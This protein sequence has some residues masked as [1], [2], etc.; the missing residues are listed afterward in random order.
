MRNQ[1]ASGSCLQQRKSQ[2][3]CGLPSQ[4][5]ESLETVFL[6][7]NGSSPLKLSVC[8]SVFFNKLP[9]LPGYNLLLPHYCSPTQLPIHEAHTKE[10]LEGVAPEAPLP[11]LSSSPVPS[12]SLH[13]NPLPMDY[14]GDLSGGKA[15]KQWLTQQREVLW[16]SEDQALHPTP[17]LPG[18]RTSRCLSSSEACREDPKAQQHNPESPS[19]SPLYPSSPPGVPTRSETPLRTMKESKYPK[20]S[21]PAMPAPSTTPASLPG[22]QRI[23]C[24]EGLSGSKA[25]W[26]TT[27]KK[28]VAQISKPPV[29]DPCQVTEPM[30]EPPGSGPPNV[31]HGYEAQWRTIG[32]KASPQASQPSVL[33]HQPP[34]SLSEPPN[35]SPVEKYS[36][37]KSFWGNMGYRENPRV[38]SPML[39]PCPALDSLSKLQEKNPPEDSFGYEPQWGYRRDSGNPCTFEFPSLDLKPE[40]CETRPA[41]VPSGSETLWKGPQSGENLW[42]FADLVSSPSL[43]NLPS[44]S[45]LQ[46]LETGHQG[47]M[48]E[49]K[50]LW[51][52]KGQKMYLWVSDSSEPA[53]RTPLAPFVEP[54]RINTVDGLPRV[55]TTGKDT[56][57]SRN[58]WTSEPLSLALSSPPALVLKPLRVIPMRVLSDEATCGDIQS[59]KNSWASELPAHSLLQ[60]LCGA[61]PLV[62]SDSQ[63]IMRDMEQKENYYA[64]LPPVWSPSSLASS[65]SKSHI[66]EPFGDQSKR[67]P[68]GEAVEQRENDWATELPVPSSLLAPLP[69]LHTD[70]KF[71]YKKVQQKEV[72][73]APSPPI[74]DSLHPISQPP[75]L[76]EALKIK[77][78]QC[79]L[80]K[81]EMLE[82][83]KAEVPSSHG[84]A[85]PEALT[86]PSIHAWQ[87]SRE[88]EHR[89]KKL[90][91][92]PPFRSPDPSQPV[93]SSSAPSSTNPDS[94]R[95]PSWA[96]QM[97]HSSSLHLHST[98]W[99]PLHVQSTAPQPVQGSH[100]CHSSSSS[101]PQPRAFCRAEQQSQ[102]EERIKGKMVAQIPAHG[103][104]FH[105]KPSKNRP[106]LGKPSNT[107]L[108]ASGRRQNKV[109]ALFQAK[110]RESPR[111]PKAADCGRGNARPG[112]STVTG[113]NRPDQAR[114]PAE[115]PASG[116][117]QGSQ[118]KDQAPRHTALPHQPPRAAG[119]QDLRRAGLGTGD[120][121]NPRHCKHCPWAD[122]EMHLPTPTPQ[123]PIT[124][125]LQ[126]VLATFQGSH[127]SLPT[128]S[129]Q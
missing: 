110:K 42:V 28:E 88:L 68:A 16:V 76:A 108:L 32:N 46:S 75:T 7:S 82:G 24:I 18:I 125:G 33:A 92:S 119:P 97:T 14:S 102:K 66:N 105:K 17:A 113:K 72:P 5:S 70:L 86:H 9:F 83:T 63:P 44:A 90:Q 21:K 122:V 124:R 59:R 85:I 15:H 11:P 87:W 50:A 12:V 117:F 103:P 67:K 23:R 6:S 80:Q 25:L 96:P 128:K 73:W 69:E 19:T 49:S 94:Q 101:Q 57:H 71:V 29:L 38:K 27:E 129:N 3:F 126:R 31:L 53:Q 34:V 89:L 13:L 65:V 47:L 104:G 40:L 95:L 43:H 37:P 56:E 115:V 111:K 74:E 112:S 109:L 45:L 30:T 48:S 35:V 52:T 120:T 4:H 91:K 107:V 39:A 55:E 93:C 64:P 127:R 41:C 51:D 10:D 100:W 36:A 22:L 121:H 2:L 8:P 1:N 106:G 61:S 84:Q 62:V 116:R 99:H 20:G 26:E 114:R 81:G 79:G 54:H 118:H 77:P 60:D 58:S 98:C 123:T 78:T